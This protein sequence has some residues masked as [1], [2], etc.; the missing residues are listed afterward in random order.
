MPKMF[1]RVYFLHSIS[2]MQKL[3]RLYRVNSSNIGECR[4]YI[5]IMEEEDGNYYLGLL[6]HPPASLGPSRQRPCA[7]QGFQL[8]FR[9]FLK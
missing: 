6:I 8:R 1:I 4:D 7:T 5:G 2:R 3:Q 9:V